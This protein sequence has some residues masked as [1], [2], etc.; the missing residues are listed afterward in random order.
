MHQV[1]AHI[2]KRKR[3]L[4]RK[5]TKLVSLFDHLVVAMGVINLFATMPQVYTI[6]HNQDA[7]G[8]S[9]LSWGYYS[10]FS[11]VLLFYGIVHREKPIIAT[12]A[13]AAVLYTALKTE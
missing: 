4:K 11:A 12:Y 13:G 7:S 1:H 3:K 8:V 5:N 6:W 10:V 2:N 9:S